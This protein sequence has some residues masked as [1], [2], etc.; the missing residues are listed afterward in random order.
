MEP[1][2]YCYGLFLGKEHVEGTAKNTGEH[3]ERDYIAL[4]VGTTAYRVYLRKGEESKFAG[5]AVGDGCIVCCRPTVSSRGAL[6]L[7]SGFL[8]K[9]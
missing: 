1:G 6:T 7:G 2:F 4:A 3:Y 9:E 8:Y 5:L